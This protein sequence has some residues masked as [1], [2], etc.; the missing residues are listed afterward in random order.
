M[1]SQT[2]AAGLCGEPGIEHAAVTTLAGTHRES[3]SLTVVSTTGARASLSA[4][5]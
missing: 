3:G 2:T 5:S 1:I 4:S